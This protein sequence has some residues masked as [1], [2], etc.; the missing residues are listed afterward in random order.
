MPG[1]LP[2]PGIEPTSLASPGS[3]PLCYLG[4]PKLIYSVLISGVQQN[5]SVIYVCIYIIFRFFSIIGYYKILNIVPGPCLY[6]LYTVVCI[7]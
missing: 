2:D 1:D 4:S 7:C 3:L 5:D 6:A